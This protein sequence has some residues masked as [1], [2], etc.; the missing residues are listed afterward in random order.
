MLTM[1]AD[2]WI[3]PF[4]LCFICVS[5]NEEPNFENSCVQ[6]PDVCETHTLSV[7]L[8]SSVFLPCNFST[9]SLNWVSWTQ[10]PG[11]DL[12]HLTSKGRIRFLDHRYGRVK[13]FPNQGSEGNYSICIDELGSSDLGCYRC[14]QG[15]YCHQVVLVDEAGGGALREEM[16]LLIYIC[17]AVAALI[18]LSV[19]GYCCMKCIMCCKTKTLDITNNPEG[20]ATEGASAP[21]IRV[22]VDQLQHGVTIH[23]V[24][25]FPTGAG[26]DNLVYENDDQGPSNQQSDPR[27]YCN[28]VSGVLPDPAQS[29]SGIYPNLNQFARTESHRTKQGFHRE[30]FSRLRQASLSRHFYVNQGEIN[31]QQA[32][33]T[34]AENQR[35][36]GLGKKKAKETCDYKNPIYNRSTDQLN[37]L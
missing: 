11:V 31:K 15:H 29:T 14:E 24:F 6:D 8:G 5:S 16:R 32:M 19:G 25:P 17:V 28:P 22:P 18:L 37:R 1:N 34:Q 30:L 35:K 27:N 10:T 36:A 9:R 4:A 26:N 3:F 7:Q 20:A 23:T 33:S 21:P 2:W 13:A 12:V